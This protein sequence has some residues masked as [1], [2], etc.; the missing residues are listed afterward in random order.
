MR[1]KRHEVKKARIEIIPVIDVVFFLLVFSMLSALSMGELNSLGAE[2]PAPSSG[3]GEAN[4]ITVNHIQGELFLT[5]ETP[6]AKRQ[7]PVRLVEIAPAIQEEYD[8]NPEVVVL[9]NA[10]DTLDFATGAALMDE[11]RKTPAAMVVPAG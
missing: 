7:Q 9:I 8:R 5:F 4:R 11:V 1:I 3:T 2:V 10:Q 6:G